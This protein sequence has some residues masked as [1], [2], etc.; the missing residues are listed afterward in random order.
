MLKNL[1][2]E[3][4]TVEQVR[5]NLI[6]HT[7]LSQGSFYEVALGRNRTLTFIDW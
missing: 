5:E 6:L 1:H 7:G 3:Q 2:L 4:T